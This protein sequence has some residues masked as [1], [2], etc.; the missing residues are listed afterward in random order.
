MSALVEA[1]KDTLLVKEDIK[2]IN[3]YRSGVQLRGYYKII[4]YG[5]ISFAYV[6]I[7]SNE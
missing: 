3:K 6:N 2:Y 4:L 7:L 5:K 1:A